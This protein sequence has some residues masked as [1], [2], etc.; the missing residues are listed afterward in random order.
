MLALS[1]EHRGTLFPIPFS[2]SLCATVHTRSPDL[3]QSFCQRKT[4]LL[5]ASTHLFDFYSYKP[6]SIDNWYMRALLITSTSYPK[7]WWQGTSERIWL[8]VRRFGTGEPMNRLPASV[9]AATNSLAACLAVLVNF[10]RQEL[11]PSTFHRHH[12]SS[13]CPCFFPVRL[14]EEP[15]W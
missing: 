11:K 8:G 2:V 10:L 13:L 9:K 5:M 7:R 15:T 14:H 4:K 6:L 12:P 1:I 3:S